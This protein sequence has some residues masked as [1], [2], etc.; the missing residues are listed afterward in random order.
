LA[1][2][3]W[4]AGVVLLGG[5]RRTAPV[6]PDPRAPVVLVSIDT[7]RADRLPAYGYGRGR[8]PVLDALARE[9]VV[10][11]D[12][13]SHCPLTLP[14]HS[15]MFT[16]LLPPRTGVRDNIGFTLKPEH[17]TLA[18]RFRAAG[19]PTGGAVSAYVLRRQTGIAQGF[20]F[21]EDALELGAS[22]EA[23]GSL[24]RDGGVAVEAL[25]QWIGER[26]DAPFF[27]FLHLYEPH[28][29]YDPP[30]RHRGLASAYDGEVA[31]A[32]E[33]TGRL[34]DRLRALGIYERSVIAVTSDHGEGLNQ[35]GEEEHGIFLYREAVHVPLILRLPGGARGKTRVRGVAGL[36][37]LPATLLDLA[38]LEASGLDGRSLRA[39][40][41]A[42][43]TDRRPVYSETMVPRYH[44]G[45]S[46]LYAVTDPP[47]RYIHAPKP[48][49]FDLGRDPGETRNLV[50]ER[51]SAAAAMQASL[52]RQVKLGELAKP[53][54]TSPELREKL[55]A[56]GY[57]GGGVPLQ[58]AGA[59][60]PD[61]KDKI[62]VYQDLKHAVALRDAG[63]DAEAVEAFRK[64]LA[65]NPTFLD[66]WET[67]GFILVRMGRTAEGIA[68]IDKVL[69]MDPGRMTAHLALARVYALSG[70]LEKAI[71]HAEV[72]SQKN[73]GQAFEILA[74]LMMDKR[75]TR[76]AAEFARRSVA[77]DDQRVGSWFVLGTIARQQGDCERALLAF[78][79]AANAK[80]RRKTL[81]VL[82][83]HAGMGDC[84]AR[85]G[86][87]AEAEK[88]FLE[89][90]RE[91]PASVEGRVGLAMLYRSQSRDAEARSALGGLV[92]SQPQP[93]ADSY[94]TVVRTFLILGDGPA[95]AEWAA[96]ARSQ[97]P[98]D[99]RFK[100]GGPP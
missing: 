49:L 33:L 63:R 19:R 34:L 3:W 11:E 58:A 68:A 69:R 10:F 2:A 38:G 89:E 76:L 97:F 48:E 73:P 18:A 7:L 20:D 56:L 93:S 66:A 5:C 82:N 45:W 70:R 6:K 23:L 24:Q 60:L 31:Y 85:L 21:Y 91:I 4:L 1:G 54:E 78:R 17:E 29:P 27:A 100:P 74:Q 96:R 9:G 15:S 12:V 14:S 88:E 65:E 67:L 41:E 30:E 94:A 40:I 98:G 37:D 43:Q 44:F 92:T 50:A 95:A 72:A 55:Q 32:D 87:A 86:R 71:A 61:P 51:E 59:E 64:V 16:G 46:E 80:E 62:G 8:T 79:K 52:G 35:H 26:R 25:A 57:V 75:D 77:A 83:L 42:G 13:Y 53:E 84:L 28:S 90:V 39:A 36:V 47:L 81:R 22:L 99:A